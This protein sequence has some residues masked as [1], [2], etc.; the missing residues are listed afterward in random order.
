MFADR[1]ERGKGTKHKFEPITLH[2]VFYM[3][4]LIILVI[5]F[6]LKEEIVLNLTFSQF[7]RYLEKSTGSANE[8]V[9]TAIKI[10]IAIK[11]CNTQ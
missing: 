9:N 10:L 2:I 3:L 8:V 5:S 1:I 11:E 4:K 7:E 6:F